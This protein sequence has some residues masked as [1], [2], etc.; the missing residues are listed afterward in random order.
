MRV[1]KCRS[2]HPPLRRRDF[3]RRR[4]RPRSTSTWPT[5]LQPCGN[6]IG[7]FGVGRVCIVDTD[8]D[9]SVITLIFECMPGTRSLGR[10]LRPCLPSGTRTG[11]TAA[12]FEVG[13]RFAIS[14]QLHRPPERLQLPLAF[15]HERLAGAQA[16]VAPGEAEAWLAEFEELGLQGRVLL[17]LEPLPLHRA[18]T[19]FVER[20][21]CTLCPRILTPVSA[22]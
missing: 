4:L 5:S 12:G 20:K 19:E 10:A 1:R 18:P 11:S 22:H 14:D 17:Q 3:R 16:G 21:G 7:S 15:D 2:L 8:Y 13:R 6:S 9:S